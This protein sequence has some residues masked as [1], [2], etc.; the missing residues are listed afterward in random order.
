MTMTWI[1]TGGRIEEWWVELS[2]Q[3]TGLGEREEH[4]EAE[5]VIPITPQLG[6]WL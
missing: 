3:L 5:E 4:G 6:D 2:L 1:R